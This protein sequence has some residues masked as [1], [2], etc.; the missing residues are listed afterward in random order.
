MPK[1]KSKEK[2]P[3]GIMS[4]YLFAAAVL[5][6]ETLFAVTVTGSMRSVPHFI[7]MSLVLSLPITVLLA[8][9]RGKGRYITAAVLSAV[10]AVPFLVEYFIYMQFKTVYDINTVTNGG[11]DALTGFSDTIRELVVS[12]PG[13]TTILLYALPCI[14][15]TVAAVRG[16]GRSELPMPA[17]ITAAVL[18]PVCFFGNYFLV[19]SSEED[20]S[21]SKGEYNFSKAVESFGL[22]EGLRL[23]IVNTGVTS[24]PEI[25]FGEG[26]EAELAL[27]TPT[28]TPTPTP[29]PTRAPSATP[30]PTPTPTP[31]PVPQVMDIDFDALIESSS[32]TIRNLNE[33][34]ASLTPSMTNE[35]TGIFRGKNLIMITAEAFTAEVID[36]ELTPTLY[37]MA[38]RGIN[39]TDFYV[40]ATAGTTGGEFSHI[41][42]LLPTAGGASVP[43]MTGNNDIHFTMSYLLGQEG[44]WG[45]A[46]HNNDYTYYS[47]NIT[48]NAMGFSEGFMGWGNGMEEYVVPT[49]PESDL[50]MFTGTVPLYIHNSPFNAYYMTVSGHSNYSRGA[51]AMSRAHWDETAF[52]EEASSERV[53]AYIAANLELEYSMAYLL[54]QLENEGILND[55]VIVICAD[56]Y[57]YG[58]DR[59]A[60][61]GYMPYLSELYGYEVT[62]MVERD[63]NRCIIWSGCLEDSD[64]IIVDTP[65]SSIDILPTLLNLFG[66]TWDSRLLPGRDV[67]SDAMPLMFNL[68]YDWKTEYGTYISSRNEF[69]PVSEDIEIPEG[70]VE[71]IREI[72]RDKIQYCR[73][74]IGSHYFSYLFPLEPDG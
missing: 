52:M 5:W 66:L 51:N 11:A 61:P 69:I 9:I 50:E 59:N 39:F 2:R 16:K 72:V 57:P 1:L 30:T 29:A 22:I 17:V 14:G 44:Y 31:E 15:F 13:I 54:E 18:I 47:R 6:Y 73:G 55:T 28:S 41:F 23:D 37:R 38:T 26:N 8:F 62:N 32:G 67:L 4:P 70:Y 21:A 12:V 74:V 56:H 71:A 7:L 64:P 42:G 34:V 20:M 45:Q 65:T 33:Y 35:Y 43:I 46:Y 68:N 19:R 53:R 48:H 10:Y 58:L 60:G 63:H 25:T 40:P 24:D 36:P 49:W 3:L 27:P